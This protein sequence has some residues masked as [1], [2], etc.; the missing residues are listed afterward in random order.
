MFVLNRRLR[1]NWQMMLSYV[2]SEAT[3]NIDNL[4][5]GGAYGGDNAGSFLNTPNSLVN[6]EG[7]LTNDP[8][9]AVKLQ[10]SY[11]IPKLNL[12]FSG[13]YT[14]NTGDTY[15][16]RTT[17]LLVDGECYDF[18]QGTDRVHGEARG[19]RR[20]EDKSELDLR[21]EWY[22]ELG[23]NDDR[24]GIFLDVFNVTNQAR[25]TLVEGSRR[26]RL[27]D[28]PHD[29]PAAHLP[30]RSEVQLLIRRQ[31]GGVP[32]ARGR[33]A[34]AGPFLVARTE[35]QTTGATRAGPRRATQ[36]TDRP[37]T[38]ARPRA[39]PHQ[40]PTSPRRSGRPS[41]AARGSPSA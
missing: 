22:M 35:P 38:T 21:A 20:L 40:M 24:F 25:F 9:H 14:F 26:Q 10:G 6:A 18:N 19:S 41:Q 29:Q 32:A 30:H 13:N 3:G 36:A 11:A 4:S 16:I 23:E 8:T 34:I 27:R 31:V 2:Y 33:R 1:D 15:N 39:S 12:L 37:A 7:K 5:F 28:R 17:C